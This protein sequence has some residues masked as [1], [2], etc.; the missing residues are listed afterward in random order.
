MIKSAISHPAG[1]SCLNEDFRLLRRG[2]RRQERGHQQQHLAARCTVWE[3]YHGM[4]PG[5]GL[6][7]NG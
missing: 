3:R 7:E 6:G 5:D 4:K 2:P 1:R